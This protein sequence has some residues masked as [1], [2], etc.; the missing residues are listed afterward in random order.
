MASFGICSGPASAAALAPTQGALRLC[1]FNAACKDE[2]QMRKQWKEYEEDL[3]NKFAEIQKHANMVCLQEVAGKVWHLLTD[4]TN[5]VGTWHADQKF[6]MMWDP[7]ITVR[8]EIR[9][10]ASTQGSALR[11]QI[12]TPRGGWDFR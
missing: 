12:R 5:W 11:D 2:N 7:K 1:T 9:A 3:L 4:T 8:V 10:L 6:G